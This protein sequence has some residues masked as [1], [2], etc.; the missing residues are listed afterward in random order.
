MRW[1]LAA[2]AA[3]GLVFSGALV[4]GWVRLAAEARASSAATPF[5]SE[6]P[7]ATAA[8]F[9]ATLPADPRPVVCG[10]DGCHRINSYD[11]VTLSP[12]GEVRRLEA[13]L[14]SSWTH[15]GLTVGRR[16]EATPGGELVLTGTLPDAE[17]GTATHLVLRRR[18]DGTVSV[19]REE[20]G[21]LPDEAGSSLVHP[22]TGGLFRRAA[23]GSSRTLLAP[24]TGVCVAVAETEAAIHCIRE[25][26][27]PAS[28]PLAED[29]AEPSP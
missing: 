27:E 20:P 2:L 25:L 12:S 29:D 1:S 6:S 3:S 18:A 15:E 7:L 23:D 4:V 22:A 24:E 14:D 28:P 16:L 8:L 26:R 10:P 13:L 21:A 5:A 11:L 19:L 9:A 17:R